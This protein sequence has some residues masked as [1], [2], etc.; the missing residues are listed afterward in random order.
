VAGAVR[1]SAR[2][3]FQGLLYVIKVSAPLDG[4]CCGSGLCH[5]LGGSTSWHDARLRPER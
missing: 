4:S 2:N 1:L 5:R 3:R